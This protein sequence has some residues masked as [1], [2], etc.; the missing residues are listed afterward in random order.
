MGP[1][2]DGNRELLRTREARSGGPGT[3]R[4]AAVEPLRNPFRGGVAGQP[5]N[6]GIYTQPGMSGKVSVNE[7]RITAKVFHELE[8]SLKAYKSGDL[9]GSATHLEKLLV[10]DPQYYP[11]HNALGAL[12]VRLHEYEKALGEFAEDNSCGASIGARAPQSE[13]DPVSIEEISGGGKRRAGDVA[14]RSDEANNA[15]RTCALP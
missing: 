9:L 12:Y 1:A 10:I 7:L 13:R 8:Q 6:S 5:M 15:I 3:V 11:A 14:D 2:P 4:W